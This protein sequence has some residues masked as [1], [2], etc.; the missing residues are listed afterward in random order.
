MPTTPLQFITTG[1]RFIAWQQADPE[2]MR[3][4]Y[5]TLQTNGVGR[6]VLLDPMHEVP[7]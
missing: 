4:V 1:L 3:L 6:F 7:P 5:R 2:F